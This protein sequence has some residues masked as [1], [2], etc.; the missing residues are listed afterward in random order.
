[1]TAETKHQAIKSEIAARLPK[2]PKTDVISPQMQKIL[3]LDKKAEPTKKPVDGLLTTAAKKGPEELVKTLKALDLMKGNGEV[4]MIDDTHVR[5]NGQKFG[6]YRQN[7]GTQEDRMS[8]ATQIEILK[9]EVANPRG[10]IGLVRSLLPNDRNLHGIP[11]SDLSHT[12][13]ARIVKILTTG[14]D[15]LAND[16]TDAKPAKKASLLNRILKR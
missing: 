5:I 6:L 12:N 8:L 7:K 11:F 10:S 2:K 14:I 16:L 13:Q 1:M 15:S 4:K 9:T 3:D